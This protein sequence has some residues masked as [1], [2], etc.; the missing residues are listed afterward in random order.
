[1]SAMKAAVMRRQTV[2]AKQAAQA[3]QELKTPVA[4]TGDMA[5][6]AVLVAVAHAHIETRRSAR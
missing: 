2:A 1:M 3:G 5:G 6:K 4:R